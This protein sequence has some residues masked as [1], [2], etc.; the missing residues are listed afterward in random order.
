MDDYEYPDGWDGQS[1]A[2]REA[3]ELTDPLLK[4]IHEQRSRIAALEAV[5]REVERTVMV[6]GERSANERIWAIE[7][8]LDAAPSTVLDQMIREAKAKAWDRGRDDERA[9]NVAL[10]FPTNPYRE[11][12]Q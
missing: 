7:D 11:E 10:Q 8:M 3:A 4:V 2:D 1:Q 9:A 5:V 12:S 6:D